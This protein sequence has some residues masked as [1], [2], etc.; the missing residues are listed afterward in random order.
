M[1]RRRT[2][3]DDLESN[4][5]LAGAKI[6]RRRFLRGLAGAGAA[7]PL[8]ALLAACGGDDD[9][10]DSTA[11]SDTGADAPTATEADESTATENAVASDDAFPLTIEH[12]FGSTTI[13]AVPERVVTVDWNG[14]DFVLALGVTPVGVREWLGDYPFQTRPWAQEQQD[15]QELET[16]GGLE[17]D[18]ERIAAL[19]PDVILGSYAHLTEEVYATLSQIAPTIAHPAGEAEISWQEQMLLAGRVLGQEARAEEIVAGIEALYEEAR[20]AHP[21]FE[22][23]TAAFVSFDAEGYWIF[24]PTDVRTQFLTSLGFELPEETG[25]LSHERADGLEHDAVIAV[26]SR[27]QFESDP[28]YGALDIVSEGRVIYL[29]DWTHDL[30]AA[31]GFN[32]PLSLGYL[33]E[34]IVPMLA[35]AVDGD[36]A[37]DPQGGAAGEA[38]ADSSAAFPV[39]FEHKHG[40]TTIEAAPE[41]IVLVGLVEQ[42]ALLAL[43]VVPVATREWY[44][45]KP[46]AIFPWAEEALGG[47]E[48]PVVLDAAELD[49]E[50]IAAL[51]PD[52]IVGLYAGLTAEEYQTL[53]QIAPTIAQPAEYVD[54]GIPWQELTLKI[55]QLVGK[56]AEAEELVA[57][58]E[59]AFAEARAAHPEFEGARAVV[60]SPFGLPENYWV[61]ASQDVR[62]RILTSLGFEVPE[63]FDEMAGDNFGATVSIEQLDLI[64][65]LDAVIWVS[66]SG[67][68]EGVELYEALPLV[69]EGRALYYGDGDPVYDAMNFG[70]VLSLPFALEHLAP[71]LAAAI[72]GDPA[73][74]PPS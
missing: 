43:G 66:D 13:E 64:G 40:S 52:V 69:R 15:G 12:A 32:S 54:W 39:T 24:E 29:D 10:E 16:V 59:E 27:E 8:A 17:L 14:A 58:V 20:A 55:G 25:A 56:E 57:S 28:L 61:Y 6:S 62:G 44:G 34:Q 38:E 45:E 23:M 1:G 2:I 47:A 46:G 21:E 3:L 73:T 48:P 26:I 50:Q 67:P 9:D 71:A 74:E 33:L 35:A 63:V 30:A 53:S 65:D 18:I 7:I 68:F 22:G 51:K 4:S 41:R 70:T 31:I 42:D 37:T 49:F 72:D 11:T 5:S 19:Q 60:A 36:P